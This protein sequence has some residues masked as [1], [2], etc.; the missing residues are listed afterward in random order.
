MRLNEALPAA[1]VLDSLFPPGVATVLSRRSDEASELGPQ[2]ATSAAPFVAPRLAEFRHGRACAR[3]ALARLGAAAVDIPI[4]AGREPIWPP[5]VVGSISHDGEL[6]AAAVAW[7]RIFVGVGV[8]LTSAAALESD[9]IP[10]ICRPAE[11][12]RLATATD[13]GRMA[14]MIFG[15]KE[16]VYKALW[17][18][19]RQILDFRDVEIVF[20]EADA[21]FA[22][23]SHTELCPAECAARLLGR[24]VREKD[25]FAAGAALPADRR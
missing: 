18:S 15:I 22:V 20:D 16:A 6:A 4:G 21:R 8:D 17:P 5:G 11:M 25:Y 2:E 24:Y 9:L 13:P 10:R 3:Q 23:V 7:E 19:L 14:K 12:E 1:T